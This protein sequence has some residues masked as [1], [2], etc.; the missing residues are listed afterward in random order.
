MPVLADTQEIDAV[1]QSAPIGL[2][3]LDRDLRYVRVN[4]RLADMNRRPVSAHIGRTVRE[5]LPQVADLAEPIL[6]RVL[7]GSKPMAVAEIAGATR[8]V[9]L[10]C[11]P[12]HDADGLVVGLN[13]VVDDVTDR[14][15]IEQQ[16]READRL[17]DD[18]LALLGHELRNPLAPIIPAATILQ[19]AAPNDPDLQKA[20]ETIMRQAR[21]L[22]RLVDDLLDVGRV[23]AGKV[24]LEKRPVALAA[25][26]TEAVESCAPT[27]ERHRHR[28][29]VSLPPVPIQL[30]VDAS[31]IVQVVCNLLD[32]AAK[33]MKPGG[34]IELV[35]S[36]EADSV[37][38]RVRDEG[39]G[40]RVEMLDRIF[41][42]FVQIDTSA[43]RAD[44]G[45]GLGLSLVKALV[46]MHGG[47]V[48]ARSEG[49]GHGSEFIVRLPALA[50]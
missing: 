44:G 2:C 41:D 21:Q 31:R 16:L 25:I 49:I 28:L 4:Q 36:L 48:E 22:S 20:C 46:A 7:D 43:Y 9:A 32:N 19:L 24:R 1:Y 10:R 45:L 26:I 17:K 6:R 35:A 40:L 5:L 37:V 38:V 8:V 3:V 39:V 11:L 29:D 47:T 23:A 30:D 50:T 42:R 34:R 18:F 15:S 27:V 13:V 33:Y 12:I 14:K